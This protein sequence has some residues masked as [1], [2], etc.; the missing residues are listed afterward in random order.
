MIVDFR[1]KILRTFVHFTLLILFVHLVHMGS[2]GVSEAFGPLDRSVALSLLLPKAGAETRPP[3]RDPL[4]VG[5]PEL[6][7][8][9]YVSL[10]MSSSGFAMECMA[11]IAEAAGYSLI[12]RRYPDMN[13]VLQDLEAG[14]IQAVP[15]LPVREAYRRFADFT[16]PLRSD[17]VGLFALADSSFSSTSSDLQ[18][19]NVGVVRGGVALS[20]VRELS[21]TLVR[22]ASGVEQLLFMLLSGQ[23]DAII[24]PQ[25]AVDFY[26]RRM[27]L[28]DRIKMLDGRLLEEHYAIAVGKGNEGVKN[29][30]ERQVELFVDSPSHRKLLAKWCAE[31]GEIREQLSLE[32]VFGLF[33]LIILC[34]VIILG[35]A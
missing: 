19:R 32:W 14:R 22:E 33:T 16:A 3:A 26:A 29:R 27:E 15:L 7:P 20:I 6:S 9:D 5:I 1:R 2:M 28:E 23:V 10:D 4:V 34:G 8:P 21:G 24:H 17:S 35:H 11:H 31:D 30:L 18:G 13:A 12:I 25:A